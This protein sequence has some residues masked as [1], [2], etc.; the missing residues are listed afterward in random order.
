MPATRA[1][2]KSIYLVGG[3]DE[4]SIKEAAS[5]LAEKL[6]PKNGG[7]FGVEIIEGDATNQDAALKVIGRVNEALNTV[8]FFGG[9]KLVWLKSTD[10]LG[11]NVVT[12]TEAVK[13]ALLELADLLKRGLPNGVR[14]LISAVG[15]DRRKTIYKTI[16]KTGEVQFF[17]A[18][19]EGKG[20]GDE[21][22]AA[23]IQNRLRMEK[24]TML[25]TAFETFRGLVAPNLREIANELEKVSI[26]VGKRAE[27]TEADV[28]AI[29]SASR[30]SVIWELTDTLGA[31][32]VTRAIGALE[33]LLES[34]E[35]AIGVVAMLVSQFRL[36]LLMKDL[37]TRKVIGVAD[38]Q[39][40]GF[41]FVKAFERLPEEEVAHFP[42]TKE[43]APPSAWR[44]YRCALA[45]RNF[46][47]NELIRAMDLLLEAN[48]Q[49]VST[50]LDARLV[51]EEVIVKIALK[52]KP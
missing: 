36:M 8:G 44:L 21:E 49:L 14:L 19:E 40:A 15:C 50:Q 11:D 45:A 27:I 28:T 1:E 23:F 13:E 34:G 17:E 35:Q 37:M 7:E 2:T 18:L 16:E 46:S 9:E 31:R 32:Q 48:R 29:C 22:I 38:G 12:R 25:S 20:H 4:F 42:K 10:L 52:G 24:K 41:Q 26:Y 43:G 47:I 3:D 51:L 33:N 39:G 5:K 6:A 30:Q